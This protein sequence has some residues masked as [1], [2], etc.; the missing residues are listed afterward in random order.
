MNNCNNINLPL[1]LQN[2]NFCTPIALNLPWT[3]TCNTT[4][5]VLASGTYPVTVN[6]SLPTS[7]ANLVQ[8]NY[9]P[10]SC[11]WSTVPQ[12]DCVAANSGSVLTIS[13][14]PATLNTQCSSGNQVFSVAYNGVGASNCC[15]TGG[16][17][18]NITYNSN[19]T[20]TVGTTAFGRVYSAAV[21]TIPPSG[22]GG[23]SRT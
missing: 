6:P 8:V 1:T 21:L 10:A 22:S 14:N 17:L 2:T 15:A 13:L 7:A 9:N 23:Y 4:S 20:A 16:P 12:N 18:T 11:P 19:P 3:I 5:A